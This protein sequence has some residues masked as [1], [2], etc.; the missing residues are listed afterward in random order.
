LI[1]RKPTVEIDLR[2]MNQDGKRFKN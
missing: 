1:T 2:V